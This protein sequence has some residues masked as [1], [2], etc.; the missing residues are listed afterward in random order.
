MNKRIKHNDLTAW[1][2]D[3]HAALPASYLASCNKFFNDLKLS[4]RER[5]RVG[6]KATSSQAKIKVDKQK[7]N[8]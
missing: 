5:G 6:P 7:S 1:F 8:I 3:D 2:T 4:S